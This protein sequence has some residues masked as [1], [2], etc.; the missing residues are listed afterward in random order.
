[1]NRYL[2][3]NSSYS[4]LMKT[5]IYQ[6]CKELSLKVYSI[7]A[8]FPSS[9]RF[10]IVDQLRRATTSIGANFAESFV[11]STP[12]DKIRFINISRKSLNEVIFF[13]DLSHSLGY[14]ELEEFEEI[15][16]MI[17]STDTKLF[18]FSRSIRTNQ[19]KY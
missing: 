3:N 13:L 11:N 9:E 19:N 1:M 4:L 10:G 5:D 17:T 14:L 16:N 2:H 7:T 6:L 8:S 12:R 18:N 15:M